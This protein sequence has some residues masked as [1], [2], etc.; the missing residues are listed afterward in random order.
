MTAKRNNPDKEKPVYM[1]SVAARLTGMHPQTLRIYERKELVSPGRTAKRTRLYSEGDIDRLKYIQQLT[2]DAGVN[3][4]GVKIIMELQK[5][6]EGIEKT[7]V[8]MEAEM[9]EA[10]RRMDKEIKQASNRRRYDLV[11]VPKARQLVRRI[12]LDGDVE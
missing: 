5:K 11:L 9:V 6:V 4:A 7:I 12:V 8:A 2:Q 1:I 10:Q 3:L